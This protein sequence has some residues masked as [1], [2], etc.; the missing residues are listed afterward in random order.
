[1]KGNIHTSSNSD[2]RVTNSK[3]GMSE[4]SD[5]ESSKDNSPERKEPQVNTVSTHKWK[6]ALPDLNSLVNNFG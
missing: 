5:P 2:R 1:M 4:V 6:K 3:M